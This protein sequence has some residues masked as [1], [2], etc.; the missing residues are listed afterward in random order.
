MNDTDPGES[1]AI[2]LTL[3]NEPASMLRSSLES[4]IAS[5]EA[6][7]ARDP[8]C[9][10]VT[11]CIIADGAQDLSESTERYLTSLGLVPSK[12]RLAEFPGQQ[13][14]DER[15]LAM[16]APGLGIKTTLR[17]FIKDQNT[18]KLDSHWWFYQRL[19][20]LLKPEHCIQIDTG[21]VLD[22]EALAEVCT[23]FDTRP[24]VAG[25][26][27]NVLIDP[28]EEDRSLLQTF[29]CADFALQKTIRW[30]SEIFSSFLSVLPGQ[31][32]AVRWQ[33]LAEDPADGLGSAKDRYLTGLDAP[34]AA[35]RMRYLAED[36]I[37]G[38]ELISQPGPTN[39]LDFAHRALCRTDACQ[40]MSEFLQQRRRWLNGN[41]FCRTWVIGRI[42]LILGDGQRTRGDKARLV[43]ALINMCVQG[44]LEWF[45]PFLTVL[46]LAA[47]WQSLGHLLPQGP[48]FGVFVLLAGFWILPAT[49]SALGWIQRWP[50]FLVETVLW[51]AG[52]SFA[53]ALVINSLVLSGQS[54]AVAALYYLT[55]PLML[56]GSAFLGAVL[57]SPVLLHHLKRSILIFI[58]LA[59]SVWL[60]LSVNAFVNLKDLSW[61]TK[62]LRRATGQ[63]Q[64]LGWRSGCIV[65]VWILSNMG[66]AFV[67]LQ[68][69]HVPAAL[70]TA[71]IIQVTMILT[72]TLGAFLIS[73]RGMGRTGW[74]SVRNASTG[75][76]VFSP[77]RSQ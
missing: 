14:D 51:M 16:C 63:A 54:G 55:V 69:G 41:M 62:G 2:C 36:R 31:F 56:I 6:L 15:S 17:L 40:D 61:G 59:P 3:F 9:K 57:L 10:R 33:A 45:L 19:C 64:K 44:L 13:L 47:T 11:I 1:L 34:D 74:P 52:A 71:G 67:I 5:V 76:D 22:V 43:P 50:R 28:V 65:M 20:P 23:L 30:P 53:T 29:Q 75:Y 46:L 24:D 37:L 38:F 21:T 27:G 12:S 48:A 4:I 25:V 68:S 60:M 70:V 35:C 49:L 32:S 8:D 77:R 18:G 26:A 66:A 7:G 72:G 58:L 73:A 42:F 39:Q